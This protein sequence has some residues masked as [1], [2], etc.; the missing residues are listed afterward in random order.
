MTDLVDDRYCF[1]CGPR[2]PVGLRVE[3]RR[4]EGRCLLRWSPSREYQ[5][6]REILHGGILATLLDEAMAHAVLGVAPGAATASLRIRF[7]KPAR[8]EGAILVEARV[9]ERKGRLIRASGVLRQEDEEKA[10]AE[11]TFVVV[12]NPRAAPSS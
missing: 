1:A 10:S 7:R 12:S 8:T 2:N 3:V 9:E 4:E 11:G 6:F 5:G